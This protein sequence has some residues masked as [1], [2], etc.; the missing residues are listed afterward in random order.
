MLILDKFFLKYEGDRGGKIAT[1]DTADYTQYCDLILNDK[2][3]Y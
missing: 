2:G 1:M 3:F